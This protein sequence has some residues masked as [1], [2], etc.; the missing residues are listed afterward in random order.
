[1]ESYAYYTSIIPKPKCLQS[2]S[3]LN[4]YGSINRY[5]SMIIYKE[6]I[7]NYI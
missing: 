1:M 7:Y 4:S 3:V 5:L 2:I 6:F